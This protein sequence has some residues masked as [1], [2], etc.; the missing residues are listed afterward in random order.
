MT[1]LPLLAARVRVIALVILALTLT[2]C[3][4]STTSPLSPPNSPRQYCFQPPADDPG[5][6]PDNPNTCT[7]SANGS[8]ASEEMA[9]PFPTSFLVTYI[10]PVSGEF[11]FGFATIRYSGVGFATYSWA[12]EAVFGSTT[13]TGDLRMS[14]VQSTQLTP[15]GATRITQFHVAT[16]SR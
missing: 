1:F 2:A 9:G 4:E 8:S 11:M 14:L 5:T 12:G 16:S 10:S 6:N 7:P 13:E 3:G 15:T